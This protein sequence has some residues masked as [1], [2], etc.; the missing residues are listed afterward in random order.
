VSGA[1]T[2]RYHGLLVAATRPPVGR[3]VLLSKLDE[4]VEVDGQR[5]ELGCNRYPGAI[6]PEGFNYLTEF[7][8]GLFPV[9]EYQAGGVRLR[10][11]VAAVH[12]ENTTLLLYEILEAPGPFALEWQPLVAGRDYHKLMHE[13]GQVQAL[14]DFDQGLFRVQPYEQTPELYIDIPGCAFWGKPDWYRN[15]EY[16]VEGARGLDMFEDLFCYGAL[17]MEVERGQRVG[18]L[19]STVYEQRRDPWVLWERERSR[20]ASLSADQDIQC[21]YHEILVRAADQFV[22]RRGTNSRS[23]IAGYHWFSDWG[24]DT[25]I[26]LPGVSLVQRRFAEAKEIL[27]TFSQ[28]ESEGMLPNR[29]PDHGEDPEYNTV[30]ASL[31][32]FVAAYHYLRYSGDLAFIRDELMPVL[33]EI[34]IWHHAGTRYRIRVDEDGLLSAGEPGVQ[35]TWMDAKV[36]DWVVTPRQGK[37]VEVNALWYNALMIFSAFAER[38]DLSQDAQHYRDRANVV[39]K[40]YLALF[41]NERDGCLYDYVDGDYRNSAIRPNQIFALSLPFPIVTGQKGHRMLRTVEEHLLTPVGLR[42]LSPRDRDYRPVYGGDQWSR[43]RAYH[44][45]TVWSWLMGPYLTAL[46]RLRGQAGRKK[47]RHLLDR[48]SDHLAE[49]GVGT[50]SEIFDAEPPHTPRGCIAQ[51]WG[52]G[53]FLRAYLE[54]VCERRP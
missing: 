45:G 25:M 37:P 28:W 10:K 29:F 36:F 1:H 22:V 14:P 38:L 11:T 18:V 7:S 26:A 33:R 9:F 20:R 35:L 8:R 2:R 13:N 4:T 51:A 50:I 31:W 40:H 54:E 21:A 53:E 12:G 46:V 48:M 16:R 6:H 30:D 39:R 19:V 5:F 17:R 52:V 42:T 34:L 44:Q 41:W 49:E 23:I 32:F 27:R 3:V 15:F 43:D 24:R 47:A